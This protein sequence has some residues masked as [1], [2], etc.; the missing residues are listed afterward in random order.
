M[1]LPPGD[2]YQV[3]QEETILSDI[4]ALNPLPASV[5]E[6]GGEEIVPVISTAGGFVLQDGLHPEDVLLLA[7]YS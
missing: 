3:A 5:L 1:V 2:S 4:L 6:I 7:I